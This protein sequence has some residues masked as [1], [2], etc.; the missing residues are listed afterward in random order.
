MTNPWAEP[1]CQQAPPLEL[2]TSLNS[3]GRTLRQPTA[4]ANG[5]VIPKKVNL[6]EIEKKR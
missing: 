3:I 1:F 5:F 6:F 4:L 2:Q